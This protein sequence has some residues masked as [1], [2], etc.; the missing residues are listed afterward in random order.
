MVIADMLTLSASGLDP[1]IS[2]GDAAY[3]LA[4][5][6]HAGGIRSVHKHAS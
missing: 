3:Q 4:R 2:P 5:V 6:K 1:D